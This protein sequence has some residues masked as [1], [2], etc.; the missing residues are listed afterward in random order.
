MDCLKSNYGTKY[1]VK[2][3]LP[4]IDILKKA[5]SKKNS[6][7]KKHLLENKRENL[8]INEVEKIWDKINKE[9]NWTFFNNKIKRLRILGDILGSKK[10]V[11]L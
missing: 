8:L 7:A 1:K 5:S 11:N 10:L 2:E 9:N 3:F 6:L 4:I